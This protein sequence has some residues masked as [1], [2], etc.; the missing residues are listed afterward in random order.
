[1]M[2]SALRTGLD[3]FVSFFFR[4]NKKKEIPF[5]VNIFM[6]NNNEEKVAKRELGEDD[7]REGTLLLECDNVTLCEIK[8]AQRTQLDAGTM[9]V[10]TIMPSAEDARAIG[11][12][13]GLDE[14]VCVPKELAFISCGAHRIPLNKDYPC[15]H[16]GPGLFV[17][18]LPGMML[19]LQLSSEADAEELEAMVCILEEHCSLRQKQPTPP[20]AQEA[21]SCE[22]TSPSP[23][24]SDRVALGV[25]AA[26]GL[27]VA[28][29]K[30]GAELACG[31]ISKGADLA[32]S[33][34][35]PRPKPTEVSSATMTKLGVARTMTKSGVAIS[36]TMAQTAI[37]VT[38]LLADQ[39]ATQVNKSERG[40]VLRD[41]R[42]EGVKKVG[43]AAVGVAADVISNA[44]EATKAVLTCTADATSKIVDHR[45][46]TQAGEACK[47][48]MGILTDTY[49]ITMNAERLGAKAIAKRAGREAA[50]KVLSSPE[51]AA[52][53]LVPPPALSA[54]P[55]AK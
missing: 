28:G 2:R 54:P 33:K 3:L 36:A 12:Q 18:A 15:L 6:S 19:G 29:I 8:G 25:L 5:H 39:I 34:V 50:K 44:T 53:P 27:A 31:G 13:L 7:I 42:L 47:Q 24:L 23:A 51:G 35:K 49:A 38:M 16:M 37:G 1:M 55:V 10:I 45:Y 41:P 48:S 22:V 20:L 14:D 46:G 17:F 4:K 9:H 26:G 11:Q 30:K 40:K 32:V 52:A 21:R 43:L